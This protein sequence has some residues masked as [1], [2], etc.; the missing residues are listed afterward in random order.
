MRALRVGMVVV[1]LAL[2]GCGGVP[3]S[4]SVVPGSIIDEEDLI[5]VAF[6]PQGPQAG[7]SQSEI[8]LGFIAAATNPQ[9]DYDV[10]RSFLADDFREEW[11]PDAITQIRT[12]VGQAR[13]ESDTAF[14]YLLTSSAH[15][16]DRGQYTEEPP[17][18]QVLPFTFVQD[19]N[20]QWRIAS[21]PDGIV[22][23]R[24]SF[25]DIFAPHP[26]YFYDP[27]NSYLVPDLRWFPETT[28]LATTVV[29]ELLKGPSGLLQQGVTNSYF[30]AGTKLDSS[31]VVE[32]GVATV[33]LSEDVLTATPEQLQ[34]MR[35]QLRDTIGDVSSVVITVGGV[36]L[37]EQD[38]GPTPATSNLTVESQ[39]LALQGD[40]FGYL[41]TNGSVGAFAGLSTDVVGLGA[42]DVTLLRD[43]SAAAVVTPSGVWLV[44]AGS[45]VPLLLDS[46]P[47]LIAPA[48][49]NSGFVWTVPASD[50]S[51]IIA[52]DA[53]GEAHTIGVPQFAGMQAVSF[54]ISR[55]GTRV[56]MLATTPLGPGLFVA[57]IV[58][59]E[60]VPT[61]L[62]S[63]IA[64]P[65]EQSSAALDATW[66]DDNTIAALRILADDDQSSIVAY[67]LGGT[68]ESL[69]RLADGVSIVG[70][71]GADGLRVLTAD[72]DIFQ[73]RGNG[74]ADT[75]ATVTVLATQ[76]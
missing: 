20:D 66:A 5:D 10:A 76:Q 59:T 30:P 64:L 41:R 18:T 40:V 68:S 37:E 31:V 52:Y 49:D 3:S 25:N 62:G 57:G 65:I 60:G 55:D 43:K 53:A 70:G 36:T 34:L 54:A 69:G 21:A 42:T 9:S 33:A 2:A 23:S 15:V 22:L 29:R 74:W 61:Q 28:R 1:V 63:L 11:D 17:A 27:T 56:L 75:G 48:A 19:E 35:Q 14:S 45:A 39:P 46:R 6:D 12:G 38:G 47:G 71:N 51:A 44:S 73:P 50:A 26:L 67:Q 16:D 58:R 7:D 72:G 8:M 4:G 32:A 24:E 13:A